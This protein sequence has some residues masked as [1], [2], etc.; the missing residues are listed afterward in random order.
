MR[1]DR[2][3]ALILFLGVMAALSIMSIALVT[4]IA[5]AQHST[6]RE[7]S[8]T[9]AFDV[10]EAA[11]DVSMHLLTEEWPGE[12]A[13]AWTESTVLERDTAF[14]SRFDLEPGLTARDSLWVSVSDDVTGDPLTAPRWDANGNGYLWV[15]AQARVNGV[16]SRVRTMVQA[17]TYELGMAKGIVVYAGG[18]LI[19]NAVGENKTNIG[20]QDVTVGGP[21]PVSIAIWGTISDPSVAWPYVDQDPP[22]KPTREELISDQMIE[23]LKLYAQRTGKYFTRQPTQEELT[24]LCVVEVP[25]G[26]TIALDQDSDPTTPSIQPFNSVEHPGVLLVLGGGELKLGGQLEYY[27]VVYCDGNVSVSHG[28]PIIYGMMIAEGSF[29]MGGVAQ[30][31]YREDCLARLDTQFQTNTKL[32]PNY[33]REL[34]PLTAE[35][36]SP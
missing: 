20:A 8:R 34:L 19:S 29:D 27:G 17:E 25:E 5:N 36:V 32:V 15:D 7:K 22:N 4:V 12:E 10:A 26:T 18:D 35:D 14:A 2:G 23:D 21:Q 16:A 24:G 13:G 1:K 9:S 31:I 6:S 30:V 11:I 33:W 28:N 3:S